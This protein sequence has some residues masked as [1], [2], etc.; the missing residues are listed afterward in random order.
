MANIL[1]LQ[2]TDKTMEEEAAAF[3]SE[4]KEVKQQK[5][6]WQELWTL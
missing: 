4:E 5:M 3:I 6:L 2:M 1:K